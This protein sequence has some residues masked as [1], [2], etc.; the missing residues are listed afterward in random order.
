MFGFF[1][2]VKIIVFERVG[3]R[4]RWSFEG[5]GDFGI[6]LYWIGYFYFIVVVIFLFG[7]H[8]FWLVCLYY[9]DIVV[10]F[11]W[12]CLDCFHF[13]G[14][15]GCRWD[16]CWWRRSF[17]CWIFFPTRIFSGGGNYFIIVIVVVIIVVIVLCYWKGKYWFI[18]VVFDG[19]W[20]IGNRLSI[21]SLCSCWIRLMRNFSFFL[22]SEIVI[23]FGIIGIRIAFIIII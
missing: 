1:I 15:P 4:I 18:I 6:R 5:F 12:G 21:F 7:C 2:I 22:R 20:L 16:C 11:R 13:P 14:P 3:W 8:W 10:F 23:A 17:F 19:G 9:I